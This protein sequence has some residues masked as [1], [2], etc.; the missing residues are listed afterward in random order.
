MACGCG[1]KVQ[2]ADPFQ[3]PPDPVVAAAATR[4]EVRVGGAR[5]GGVHTS[6]VAAQRFAKRIGGTVLPL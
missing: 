6:F 3:R 2:V 1:K 4:F 5:V